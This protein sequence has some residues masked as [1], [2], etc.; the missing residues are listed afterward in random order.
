M[1]E[2]K[3]FPQK[4]KHSE[5]APKLDHKIDH[6]HYLCVI[7]HVIVEITNTHLGIPMPL[8]MESCMTIS[9]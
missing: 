4:Q 7:S 5:E 1:P 6:W 8:N 3:A 2:V 9:I